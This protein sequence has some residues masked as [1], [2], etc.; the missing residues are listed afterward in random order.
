MPAATSRRGLGCQRPLR[1]SQSAPPRLTIATA[2]NAVTSQGDWRGARSASGGVAPLSWAPSGASVALGPSS[3]VRS[4]RGEAH[5]QQ[6]GSDVPRRAVIAGRRGARTAP[7][8]TGDRR[9]PCPAGQARRALVAITGGGCEIRTREGLPPTRFPSVRHRP[10]RRIL[11]RAS[12]AIGLARWD[13]SCAVGGRGYSGRRPLVRR[14]PAQ[15]PQGRKAA[16]VSGLWRVREG[17]FSAVGGGRLD[18]ARAVP[19][20]PACAP[21][22]RSSARSTS[23]SRSARRCCPGGSTTPTCSVARGAVA[24]PRARGSWPAR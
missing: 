15:L 11:R 23:P 20:I 13:G 10:T 2:S 19:E 7:R 21:L 6:R 12:L 5:R 16:R 8:R 24:R 22:P 14:Y 3:A 9:P 1:P 17:S 18:V 4:N